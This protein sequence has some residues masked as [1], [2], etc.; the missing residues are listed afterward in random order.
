MEEL[1][2]KDST[3]SS[4]CWQAM[5]E[6]ARRHI[7]QWLQGLLEDEVTEFLGRARYCR[8]EEGE[9][10]SR[11]GYGKPRQLTTRAGTVTVRR[12]RIRGLE[13]R[14]E[15]ALLPLF[16]RRTPEVNDLLPELYLH[17]LAL[18]DFELALRGLFG[19]AAPLSASTVARVKERWHQ[20]AATWHERSL[21]EL[22]VVYLW[23]D[24]VYVKAGLEKEKAALLVAIGGWL[25]GARCLSRCAAGTGSRPR[26]GR[27]CEGMPGS[28]D[29]GVHGW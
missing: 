9:R 12:P 23:V 16:A 22:Q 29:C 1:V 5:E 19:E 17:G 14:F 7:E 6:M 4:V 25:T 28:G 11:N 15:S 21:A 10:G 26:A 20:E 24:G 13:Q 8:R 3:Q 27:E 2:T 18:G